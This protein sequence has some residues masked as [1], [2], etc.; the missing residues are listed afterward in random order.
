MQDLTE[1]DQTL[2]ELFQEEENI[3]PI[4]RSFER[5]TWIYV[6]FEFDFFKIQLTDK[7]KTVEGEAKISKTMRFVETHLAEYNLKIAYDVGENKTY[8][9]TYGYNNTYS[10]EFSALQRNAL[11]YITRSY[12]DLE[13]KDQPTFFAIVFAN[14]KLGFA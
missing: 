14:T 12:A 3:T 11:S 8:M 5:T 6:P 10:E 4:L 13:K 2:V 7:G 1:A 9:K